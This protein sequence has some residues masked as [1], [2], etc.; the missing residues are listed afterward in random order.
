MSTATFYKWRA[1]YGGIDRSLMAQC[2]EMAQHTVQ[3]YGVSIRLAC[4]VFSYTGFT[5]NSN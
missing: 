2:K 5:D 1:K 3:Q 4:V